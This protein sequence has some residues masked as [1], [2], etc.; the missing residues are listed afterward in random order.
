MKITFSDE[1][2]A[3]IIWFLNALVDEVEYLNITADERAD[4]RKRL[5]PVF[6]CLI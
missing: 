3:A 4:I 2:Y 6:P 5:I 1:L